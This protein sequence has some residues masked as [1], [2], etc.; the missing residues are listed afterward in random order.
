M[1]ESTDQHRAAAAGKSANCAIVTVSDTRSLE[2]DEGGAI[3][4]EALEGVGHTIGDYG[5][6]PDDPDEL[7]PYLRSHLRNAISSI[8][9]PQSDF[10]VIITT[11][12]T[13]IAKRDTTI[14]VVRKLLHKELDGFGELFRMLSYEQVGSAAMLSR[15]VAGLSD[16]VLIFA[17]PG[18]PDAVRLAMEKLIV[19]ELS[20]LV[21][22]RKR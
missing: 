4:R 20:H 21:W 5:I 1:S 2:D 8:N 7:G 16:N 17:L 15:A 3:I 13:G 11:G 22:E 10:D 18:S 9:D 14:E 19:P 12:G 6:V